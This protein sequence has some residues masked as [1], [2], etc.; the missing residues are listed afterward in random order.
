M[1]EHVSER[2]APS[3]PTPKRPIA[4]TLVG[5]LALLVGLAHVV[6]GV[7]AVVNGSDASRTSEGAFDL[8]LGVFALAIGRGA[9]RMTPWAWAAFMTW[10]VIGLTHQLLRYFFYTDPNYLSMALETV[11]VLAL[12]P[13]DVQVAF[14]V[15]YPRNLILDRAARNHSDGG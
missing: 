2:V 8:A 9:L 11:A 14:G 4:V 7:L 13:L 5:V 3:P 10:T 15:R 6:A 12:T 1:S